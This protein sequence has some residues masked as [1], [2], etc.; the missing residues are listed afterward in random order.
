M[1]FWI[2]QNQ[3]AL[4]AGAIYSQ[5]AGTQLRTLYYNITSFRKVNT[6]Y[7]SKIA[8]DIE[9]SF[10]VFLPQ[11]LVNFFEEEEEYFQNIVK[12][13]S[14]GQSYSKFLGGQLTC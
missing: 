7:G 5:T 13:V 11:R 2:C 4:T 8:A 14:T 10:V 9:D 1:T 6:K 3:P 12:E